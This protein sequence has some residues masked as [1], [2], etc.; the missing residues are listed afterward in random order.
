VRNN[1]FLFNPV[2]KWKGDFEFMKI[3]ELFCSEI[4]RINR[5]RVRNSPS[6]RFPNEHE[7]VTGYIFEDDGRYQ[8]YWLL[9]D[10][11]NIARFVC[12]DDKDK[13]VCDGEDYAL[14]N[15]QGK[16]I[17]LCIDGRVFLQTLIDS[18]EIYQKDYD[19]NTVFDIVG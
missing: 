13:L 19:K 8:K 14:F 18:L 15:T 6:K 16:Y 11:D 1:E 10:P 7:L 3:E 9:Y 2:I 4:V 12:S 5:K 17:D